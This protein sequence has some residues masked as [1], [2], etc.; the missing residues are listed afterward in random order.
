MVPLLLL[1]AAPAS[2]GQ[3]Q[4]PQ[5]LKPAAALK[6][7]ASAGIVI[8]FESGADAPAVLR[9][10]PSLSL[11]Y[12]FS[13][14]AGVDFEVS[15]N[16]YA[17]AFLGQNFP[18]DAKARLKAYRLWA[19]LYG[20]RCEARLGLQKINF[21]SAAILR[22]LMWFDRLDPNDPLQLTDGVWGAFVRYWFRGGAS[23]W[24]WGLYGN[25]EVKG[26]E[27]FPTARQRPEFGAR[28]EV[29][30]GPGELAASVHTRSIDPTRGL[31]PAPPDEPS[32]VPELRLALDGKW[33]VGPGLWFEAVLLRQGFERLLNGYT[34]ML[35]L[36]T[37][38]TFGLGGGLHVLA[39]HLIVESSADAFS[40]GARTSFSA[41]SVN[42][43]L[44]LIDQVRAMV[45]H[46][47]SARDWYR[48]LFWQ[49]TYDRWS[50]FLIA[51]WNPRSYELFN[52]FGSSPFSG[53]GI[54]ATIAFNH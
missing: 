19:R 5:E 42:Y 45:F 54:Q 35:C 34:R 30:L 48:F 28:L 53:K 43:P 2:R 33:D 38:Y 36:G 21:G 31:E 32:R 41:V 9:Y 50:F 49:R 4:P 8:P 47:W 3:G 20:P 13:S 24:A 39:E 1:I 11:R 17:R 40:A 52:L 10:I 51:F 14:S 16:A 12:P 25:D 15:A 44:G 46:N 37:D 29:P 18:E 26:W 27:V 7:Q 22:P 23:V 6:G